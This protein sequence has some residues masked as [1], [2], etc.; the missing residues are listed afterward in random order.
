MSQVSV[1]KAFTE[2]KEHL[3]S[4][5]RKRLTVKDEAEDIVQEI[6]YQLSRMNE[7]SN[8]I[9]RTAAWLFRV[10]R[11]MIINWQK[12]KKDVPFSVL[13]NSEDDDTE[14]NDIAD[15]LSSDE[16][17][18]E[19][20][21]LRSIVW[22]EIETALDELPPPQR[23]IFVQTEY[24]DLS[25]KEISQ[26]TGVPVNTLLS[27]KHYAVK[28]LRKRLINLYTDFFGKRNKEVP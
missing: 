22:E 2:Y 16:I 6:F 14:L 20:E 8:P 28:H 10:A 21:I 11:N 19:T 3:V 18:P 15:I 1:V 4:F 25:V 24:W 26:K 5:V 23:D 9:E 17:T 13:I 7:M 12:K 27:R